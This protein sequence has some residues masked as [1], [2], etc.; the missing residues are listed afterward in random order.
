[1]GIAPLVAELDQIGISHNSKIKLCFATDRPIPHQEV[2]FSLESKNGLHLTTIGH[3]NAK[4]LL[5][6]TQ[7]RA[8]GSLPMILDRYPV[9]IIQPASRRSGN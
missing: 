1:M 4:T 8:G 5:E 2:I 9:R 6:C 3:L 7:L